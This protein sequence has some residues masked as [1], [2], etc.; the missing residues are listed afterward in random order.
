MP[1]EPKM[2]FT[3]IHDRHGFQMIAKQVRLLPDS[4]AFANRACGL[5]RISFTGLREPNLNVF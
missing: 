5:L 1:R 2:K 3:P 4:G